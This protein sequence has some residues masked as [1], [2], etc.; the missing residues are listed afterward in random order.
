MRLLYSPRISVRGAAKLILT[1][2]VALA[3]LYKLTIIGKWHCKTGEIIQADVD[4]ILLVIS[5][6]YLNPLY[7]WIWRQL[8]LPW[9]TGGPHACHATWFC[10]WA[11]SL[12]SMVVRRKNIP[13]GHTRSGPCWDLDTEYGNA[14]WKICRRYW[15][16]LKTGMEY[17]IEESS[18]WLYIPNLC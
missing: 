16:C 9:W 10:Q 6:Q 3:I 18:N 13:S 2:D 17:L 14:V 7:C 1:G 11:Q 15:S 5:S 4:L 8:Q 12:S